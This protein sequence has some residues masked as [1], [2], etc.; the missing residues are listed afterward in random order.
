[1]PSRC[2]VPDDHGCTLVA[3]HAMSEL[4]LAVNFARLSSTIC[5]GSDASSAE[6]AHMVFRSAVTDR[7]RATCSGVTNDSRFPNELRM[8]DATEAI[9]SSD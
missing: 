4:W 9:Q 8:Y 7:T 2:G 1:M 3:Y 5:R 6:V